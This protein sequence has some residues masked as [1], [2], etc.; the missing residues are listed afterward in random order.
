MVDFK[1]ENEVWQPKPGLTLK[2][3]SA[4]GNIFI[5]VFRR[6]HLRSLGFTGSRINDL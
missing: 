6:E 2:G 5:N 4:I 1:D 3:K